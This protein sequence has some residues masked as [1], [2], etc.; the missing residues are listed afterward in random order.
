MSSAHQNLVE[1][2]LALLAP[3]CHSV[4]LMGSL[5]DRLPL[6]GFLDRE[7]GPAVSCLE[8]IRRGCEDCRRFAAFDGDNP[9][10]SL[11]ERAPHIASRGS[12]CKDSESKFC[13]AINGKAAAAPKTLTRSVAMTISVSMFIPLPGR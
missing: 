6:F 11:E 8:R 3:R 2:R 12:V 5:R 4:S 10:V 7:E 13:A 9:L 1:S